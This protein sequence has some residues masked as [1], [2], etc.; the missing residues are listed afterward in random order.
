MPPFGRNGVPASKVFHSNTYFSLPTA[1]KL[2]RASH[3][4]YESPERI[5]KTVFERW[6]DCQLTFLDVESTQCIAAADQDSV[7]VALRG[8][9]ADKV[10]DW[11][12]DLNFD[13]VPG[14]L[15][16][17]VHEG[18][19][20]ALSNI[21]SELDAVVRRWCEQRPRKLWVT[22]H[23]LGAALAALAVARWLDASFPVA[24][25][26]TFG[27]PRTGDRDFARHF[28]FEFRPHAF[29]IVNKLDIVTRTPPRSLGYWHLGTYVYL[30]DEGSIEHDISRWRRFLTGWH[31]TIDTILHWGGEGV[32]DHS[33]TRYCQ[34]LERSLQDLV[35]TS[36]EQDAAPRPEVLS[37]PVAELVEIDSESPSLVTQ[38]EAK[39]STED[40][41]IPES[42]SSIRRPLI[43]PRRRVA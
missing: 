38:R 36:K 1:V 5:E 4:S 12:V 40:E 33:M 34:H 20:D 16:G 37:P 29:R 22:G 26:Y 28:D 11:I 14:P 27:Q 41:V 6:G 39:A 18:F 25:L 42:S 43:K 3:L 21:W 32:K 10:E 2:A 13:L 17:R 30:D 15:S 31:G 23:S 35:D 7:V 19:Y 24:G 8:T 9:Q